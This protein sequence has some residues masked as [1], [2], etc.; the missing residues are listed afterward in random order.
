MYALYDLIMS[1]MNVRWTT[2]HVDN[3]AVEVVLLY[4]N[5]QMINNLGLPIIIMNYNYNFVI[6]KECINK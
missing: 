1:S 6:I 3:W 5:S 4:K 2:L